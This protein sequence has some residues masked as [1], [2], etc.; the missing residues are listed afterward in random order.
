MSE[1]FFRLY[2]GQTYATRL[3]TNYGKIDQHSA[4]TQV[5]IPKQKILPLEGQMLLRYYYF[6][7]F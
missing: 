3:D 1:L 4:G 2:K 6:L 7:L 5:S